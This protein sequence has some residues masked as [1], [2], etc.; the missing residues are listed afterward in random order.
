VNL[1]IE[2]E[3]KIRAFSD[4]V[5]NLNE[6]EAKSLLCQ[7]YHQFV[8]KDAVYRRLIES[9]WGIETSTSFNPESL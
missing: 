7:M 8:L 5:Q 2:E 4:R 1:S 9:K 6:A 3:F